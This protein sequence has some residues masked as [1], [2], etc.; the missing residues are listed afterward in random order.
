MKGY[1][2]QRGVLSQIIFD[3]HTGQ[4]K[5]QTVTHAFESLTRADVKHRANSVVVE[6]VTQSPGYEDIVSLR[7]SRKTVMQRVQNKRTG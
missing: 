4:F 1:T 7:K 2:E 6:L 5:Q 3:A